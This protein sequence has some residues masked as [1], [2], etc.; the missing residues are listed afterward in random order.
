[1][2]DERQVT[3]DE[4]AK[5]QLGYEPPVPLPKKVRRKRKGLEDIIANALITE[6]GDIDSHLTYLG[7]H[8]AAA[9]AAKAIRVHRRRKEG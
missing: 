8:Q 9:V 7:C 1:M 2:S 6:R 5:E 4:R 3:F